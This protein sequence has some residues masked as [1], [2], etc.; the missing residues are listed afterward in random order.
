MFWAFESKAVVAQ[1]TMLPLAGTGAIEKLPSVP[2]A[3]AAWPSLP[4]TVT[5]MG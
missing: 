2:R 3:G 1:Y 5:R 4:R